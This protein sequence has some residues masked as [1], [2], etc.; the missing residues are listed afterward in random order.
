MELSGTEL[1]NIVLKLSTEKV[2]KYFS[3]KII[4]KLS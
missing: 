4:K 2:P 1:F 3:A